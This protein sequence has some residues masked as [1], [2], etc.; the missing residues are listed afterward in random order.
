MMLSWHHEFLPRWMHEYNFQK[1]TGI[2]LIVK[3][4]YILKNKDILGTQC[5]TFLMTAYYNDS[6]SFKMS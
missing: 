4:K 1:K 5:K 6:C 3:P 2:P